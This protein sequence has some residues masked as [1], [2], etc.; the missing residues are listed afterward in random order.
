MG[1]MTRHQS[2]P[3]SPLFS[4]LLPFPYCSFV[5]EMDKRLS[6]FGGQR[7]ISQRCNVTRQIFPHILSIEK[8]DRLATMSRCVLPKLRM[9]WPQTGWRQV[10]ILGRKS[11]QNEYF[12]NTGEQLFSQL[13]T[14]ESCS[15]YKM[16]YCSQ[17][18]KGD[19]KL[20]DTVCVSMASKNELSIYDP[21][22]FFLNSLDVGIAM[23]K[24]RI[25]DRSYFERTAALSIQIIR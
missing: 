25:Y 8:S 23:E 4:L 5:P 16:S 10:D 3:I 2:V 14:K 13:L 21:S 20:L 17:S 1:K 11:V 19:Q 7:F 22:S 24:Q 12:M 9:N 18:F 6:T 15:R